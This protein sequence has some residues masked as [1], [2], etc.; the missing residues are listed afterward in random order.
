MPLIQIMCAN[1]IDLLMALIGGILSMVPL[2]IASLDDQWICGFQDWP[3][4]FIYSQGSTKLFILVYVDDIIITG[5]NLLH[6]TRVIHVLSSELA[7]KDL[8]P[9]NYFLGI[10]FI[11]RGDGLLLS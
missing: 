10:E 1:F 8:G 2:S 7:L 11:P 4:L 9:F 6:I 5:N 3:I